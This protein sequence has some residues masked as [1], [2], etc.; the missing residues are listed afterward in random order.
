M[1][2]QDISQDELL[3]PSELPERV[4]E[5]LLRLRG[6]GNKAYIVGGA[7]RDL[8]LKGSTDDWDI[9]TSAR[10]ERVK[11][12]FPHNAP[13]GERHGSVMAIFDGGTV[14]ITTFRT[15]GAYSDLR[16]PDSVGYVEDVEQDLSRRDF[17]MNA[18]AW[19][20]FE[21]RLIDPFGGRSDIDAGLIRAVGDAR[22]RFSED[23][24]RMLRALRFCSS[25]C[26]EIDESVK[27]A[28]RSESG[29]IALISGERKAMELGR[30][31]RG[32]CACKALAMMVELG[33]ASAIFPG[34]DKGLMLTA[35]EN[36]GGLPEDA[37]I[38][39][40]AFIA[41]SEPAG[42]QRVQSALARRL[43]ALKLP[44]AARLH[45]VRLAEGLYEG[46]RLSDGPSVRRW[47]ALLGRE[48]AHEGLALRSWYDSIF[49]P[50]SDWMAERARVEAVLAA[51]PPL[52]LEEL[53]IR[54]SDVVSLLNG[55]KG[56][57][58]K[59]VMNR[60]YLDVLDSPELN[61]RQKLL[62]LAWMY[63]KADEGG[64]PQ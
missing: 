30:I 56:P 11:Q 39:L 28:I 29:G 13:L 38:R 37:L 51:K 6:D 60:I 21:D 4:R 14:D 52:A 46:Y 48:S 15:E 20:P 32:P 33:L 42:P 64:L 7:I 8:I 41:S 10:P 53:K 63:I 47:A 23:A 16:R 25:L 19:D 59:A 31:L 43:D 3:K 58:V 55:E 24:L 9:A 50:G 17:T 44:K 5:A 18:M 22:E 1:Q 12:L 2:V 57:K 61:D 45:A 54:G 49:R 26:F 36:I 34:L 62:M 27:G 40:A 35:A